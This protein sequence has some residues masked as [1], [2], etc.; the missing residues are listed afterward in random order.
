VVFLEYMSMESAGIEW[1][2]DRVQEFVAPDVDHTD[3][4][5]G[6]DRAYDHGSSWHD[7]DYHDPY[8]EGYDRHLLQRLEEIRPGATY[9]LTGDP[10]I[11]LT[12]IQGWIQDDYNNLRE[13]RRSAPDVE[14]TL[15]NGETADLETLYRDYKDLFRALDYYDIEAIKQDGVVTRM[16]LETLLRRYLN[17]HDELKHNVIVNDPRFSGRH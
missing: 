5:A 7:R 15:D 3:A 6:H 2:L 14:I 8:Y 9:E 1:L 17:L 13:L 12:T 10:A 11:D 4:I 16:E